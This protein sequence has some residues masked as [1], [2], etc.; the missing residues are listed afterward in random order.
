[1]LSIR[2]ITIDAEFE[3]LVPP[4]TDD[5]RTTLMT[6]IDRDGF[7]DPL[8]VWLNHGILLD[9]H[10]RYRIWEASFQDDE[11]REPSIVEMKFASRDE[12]AE[13]IIRNQLGRRNLTDAQRIAMALKLKPIIEEKSKKNK[14][15]GVRL[16][17]NEGQRTMEVV[18]DAAGVSEST[19]RHAEAVLKSDNEPVKAEMLSGKKSIAAAHREVAPPPK[20]SAVGLHLARQAITA[21]KR[22]P[23]DDDERKAAFDLLSDWIVETM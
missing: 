20:R 19:A 12:A 2:D 16:K 6:N 4:M 3:R 5:D 7:R 14:Q 21:M 9:G 18:A 8:V 23:A 17:S 15:A 11:N 22:I 1:M 13:W 10:N